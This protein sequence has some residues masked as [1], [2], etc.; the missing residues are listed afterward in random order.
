MPVS[1][2]IPL[3]VVAVGTDGLVTHWSSGAGRLFGTSREAAVG[4][5]AADLMPVSGALRGLGSNCLDPDACLPGETRCP[6]SGRARMSDRADG[7]V[8]VLWWA[9]PLV[10]PGTG[11]LLVLAADAAWIEPDGDGPDRARFSP[12]FAPHTELP[13][14]EQLAERLPG[15]LP[16]MGPAAAGRIVEQ[17]LELG[18]PVVEISGHDRVPVT[19][20]C[21]VPRHRERPAPRRPADGAAR[22][23]LDADPLGDA[24]GGRP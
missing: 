12:A 5:P 14:A 10:G 4:A 16:G 17:V 2:R 20:D 9:Y 22:G 24:R 3:A 21:G 1:G 15:V 8:D 23:A 7:P 19:P 6:T 11:G 13:D 18:C